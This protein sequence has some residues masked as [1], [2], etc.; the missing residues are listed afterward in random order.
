MSKSFYNTINLSG[1]QLLKS[2]ARA[3]AQEN[4]VEEIFKAN[5]NRHISPSQLQKIV[6]SKYDRHCP[7]TSWRRAI[8]NL[9]KR[10]VLTKTDEQVSG[11]YG[12]GEHCWCYLGNGGYVVSEPTLFIQPSLF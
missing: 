5:P 4:L 1:E 11:I 9:T 12:E 7:L 6:A 10:G 8:T 3:L 2:N